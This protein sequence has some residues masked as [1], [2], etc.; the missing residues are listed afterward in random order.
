MLIQCKI[1]IT[2][3]DS[4]NGLSV[5]LSMHFCQLDDV[6]T[7]E[8]AVLNNEGQVVE[9]TAKDPQLGS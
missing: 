7:M 8:D 5:C 6:T 4:L 1:H 3:H 2:S 9:V